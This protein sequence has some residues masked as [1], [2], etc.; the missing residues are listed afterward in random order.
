VQSRITNSGWWPLW[1]PLLA[2]GLPAGRCSAA[3]LPRRGIDAA[4]TR[5]VRSVLG[6]VLLQLPLPVVPRTWLVRHPPRIRSRDELRAWACRG[7]FLPRMMGVGDTAR[8]ATG[9][10]SE[11]WSQQLPPGAPAAVPRHAC[12]P[13][14][15]CLPARPQAA[16]AAPVVSLADPLPSFVRSFVP[17]I[18]RWRHPGANPIQ[19]H[20]R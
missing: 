11:R 4:K 2:A 9:R 5:P 19:K 13:A 20:A 12:A 10:L 14:T 6:H 8:P 1:L 7:F 15:P 17:F 3:S 16:T 18:A